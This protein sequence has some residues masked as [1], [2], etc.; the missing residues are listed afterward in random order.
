MAINFRSLENFSVKDLLSSL[1][2]KAHVLLLIVLNDPLGNKTL[3]IEVRFCEDW[4]VKH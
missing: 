2:Q 4:F 3:R 1:T